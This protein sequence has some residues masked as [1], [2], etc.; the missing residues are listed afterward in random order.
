MKHAMSQAGDLAFFEVTRITWTRLTVRLYPCRTVE[1]VVR[2]P[3][4]GALE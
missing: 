3:S 4:T 2:Q 1:K